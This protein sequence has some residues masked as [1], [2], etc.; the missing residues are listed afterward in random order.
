M[1]KRRLGV[2]AVF[3]GFLLV[4]ARA[5]AI[6]D[7]C[8]DCLHQADEDYETCK[9]S[10]EIFPASSLPRMI[11]VLGCTNDHQ[12]DMAACCAENQ[13]SCNTNPRCDTGNPP[14]EGDPSCGFSGMCCCGATICTI[15]PA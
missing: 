1:M 3:L 4:S 15:N 2:V 9:A 7:P 11:C 6:P 13:Q 12:D 8:E 14:E 10:C 5:G